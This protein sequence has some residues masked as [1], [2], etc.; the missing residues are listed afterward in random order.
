MVVVG[1][2]FGYAG[3]HVLGVAPS[4]YLDGGGSHATPVSAVGIGSDWYSC[5]RP[6]SSR[7]T[8]E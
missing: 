3:P 6:K 2:D 8:S 1:L 4:S 5:G 7:R